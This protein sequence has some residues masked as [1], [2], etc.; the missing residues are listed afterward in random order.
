LVTRLRARRGLARA[1]READRELLEKN[2]V[3]L[4][5]A[6]RVEELVAPANR[7][8]LARDARDVVRSAERRYEVSASPVNRHGVR[9][10]AS[11]LV[12]LA[13]QL[14]TEGSSPLYDR[15]AVV[16][17]SACVADVMDTLQPR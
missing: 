17:L 8:A 2:V 13:T 15:A 1:R 4:R 16:S 9:E 10:H 3:P 14:F 6:W 5:L 11:E 12:V 7:L